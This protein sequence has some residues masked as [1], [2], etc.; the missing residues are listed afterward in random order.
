[1]LDRA[2]RRAALVLMTSCLALSVV[3]PAAA[4]GR[5]ATLYGPNAQPLGQDYEEWFG[6]YMEWLQEIPLDENPLVEPGRPADCDLQDDD[7]V[8]VV[9]GPICHVPEGAAV[10]FDAGWWE[11]STAEGLGETFAELRRCAREN[12]RNDLNPN[13]YSIELWIDGERV[14]RPRRWT[15]ITPGEVVDFPQD[16]IWGVEPGRSKSVTKGF[17][18]ILKPLSEGRHVI[19]LH[20]E[21]EVVGGFDARIVLRVH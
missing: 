7:I 3:V 11:C 13:A 1:M 4:H 9:F 10:A 21:H 16:N 12:F 6:D 5:D 18:Y 8:F 14:R 2:L 15:F 19:R 17:F 20:T